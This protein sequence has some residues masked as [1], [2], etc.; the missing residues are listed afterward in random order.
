MNFFASQDKARRNTTLL[1]VL[2]AVAISALILA[3]N[4]LVVAV[5]Y[6]VSDQA[7]YGFSLDNVLEFATPDIFI[8]ISLLIIGVVIVASLIKMLELNG[9]GKSIAEKLGGKLVN[10]N[11]IDA[12]E[13]KLLNI[14]EEMAIASGTPV[15]PVYVLEEAGINAFAAGF[16]VK[17][18]VIGVS[19]GCIFELNRDQLQGVIAHEFSHIHNGDMLLNLRL[20][21][22]LYGIFF[23]G[24]TG[25]A[26]LR[27]T[28]D[29]DSRFR[30]RISNINVIWH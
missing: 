8:G 12:D 4:I 27:S 3:T 5:L 15:P 7:R 26:I 2:F 16:N 22:I 13:R 18:A 20:I 25:E 23:L 24:Q 9:G 19:R 14:V 17:D 21:G 30:F 1:V 11:T 6:F 28:N 29:R 10:P